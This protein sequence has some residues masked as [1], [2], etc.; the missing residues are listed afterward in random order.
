MVDV[1][2]L[3]LVLPKQLLVNQTLMK[4]ER[5]R[6]WLEVFPEVKKLDGF[7]EVDLDDSE[8]INDWQM[9]EAGEEP[10]ERMIERV[11]RQLQSFC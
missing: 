6:I 2:I 7:F 4:T 10:R 5:R 8:K 3:H 9:I 1:G 11:R